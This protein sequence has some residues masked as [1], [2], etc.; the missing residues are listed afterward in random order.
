[1]KKRTKNHG[2]M[3]FHADLKR[4]KFYYEGTQVP[5]FILYWRGYSVTQLIF[6]RT[7]IKAI[8]K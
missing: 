4:Y 3:A 8:P 2:F 1:M 7:E 6:N 5:I